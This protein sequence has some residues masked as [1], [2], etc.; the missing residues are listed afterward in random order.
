METRCADCFEPD[1]TSRDVKSHNP[2][3]GEDL[4]R[5]CV[6]PGCTFA[7][8]RTTAA[9]QLKELYATEAEFVQ[10][11]SKAGKARFSKRRKKHFDTHT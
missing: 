8:D 6:A 1:V 9:A 3:P 5:P 10:D 11:K 4:P 2:L 7:H